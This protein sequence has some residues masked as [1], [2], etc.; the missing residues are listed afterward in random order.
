MAVCLITFH[1]IDVLVTIVRI[2]SPSVTSSA[3]VSI[4]AH[5]QVF[6]QELLGHRDAHFSYNS[7]CQIAHQYSHARKKNIM[8]HIMW[9]SGREKRIRLLVFHLS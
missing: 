8:F 4:L 9:L 3:A 2:F 6:L 7:Y 1:R 5:V